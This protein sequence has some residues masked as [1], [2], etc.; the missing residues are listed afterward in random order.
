MGCGLRFKILT[1]APH[2]HRI[3]RDGQKGFQAKFEAKRCTPALGDS[4][5]K[6]REHR[7]TLISNR[8]RTAA[9][10]VKDGPAPNGHELDERE[11][12]VSLSKTTAKVSG[13]GCSGG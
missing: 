8:F 12:F 4:G 11:S 5:G 1:Y 7:K 9:G 13:S 2:I 3:G 10:R 6:L